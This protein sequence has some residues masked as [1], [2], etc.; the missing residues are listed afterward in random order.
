LK[1]VEMVNRDEV[2]IKPFAVS[3][4]IQSGTVAKVST[5]VSRKELKRLAKE[6]GLDHREET[7]L[8]AK[9]LLEAYLAKR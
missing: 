9:K 6:K 7:L 3:D 5:K 2:E 1:K 4:F 8:L